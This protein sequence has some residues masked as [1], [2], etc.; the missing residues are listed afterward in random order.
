MPATI[1]ATT[2]QLSGGGPT[3]L[4][5]TH[6]VCQAARPGMRLAVSK[7]HPIATQ[8][9]SALPRSGRPG[10]EIPPIAHDVIL[11]DELKQR[12][13]S[14]VIAPTISPGA[15][16]CLV[17]TCGPT[18]CGKT[19]GA[20]YCAHRIDEERDGKLAY[21]EMAP[22]QFRNALWGRSEALVRELFSTARELATQEGYSILIVIED[23]EATLFRSRQLNTRNDYGCGTTAAGTTAELLHG[24]TTL[25]DDPDVAVTVWAS[26]NYGASTFSYDPAVMAEHRM[27]D[28]VE[29]PTLDLSLVPQVV[30]AHAERY[31]VSDSVAEWL[32]E[33]LTADIVLA[34]GRRVN[35]GVEVRLADCLTPAM[36]AGILSRACL[37]VPPQE[38]EIHD[39]ADACAAQLSV[40]ARRIAGHAETG[41]L[42]MI[43]PDLADLDR[44]EGLELEPVFEAEN[45]LLD[46]A[47]LTE[48]ITGVAGH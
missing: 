25:A 10:G 33:A 9:R 17:M 28:Y 48:V 45:A 24:L 22:G 5:T 3:R 38:M 7:I 26:S 40:L 2:G 37:N 29:F 12:L 4:Y 23:A 35:V 16:P 30:R 14:V 46:D 6:T 11:S 32:I 19:T 13:E 41:D 18:G 47:S 15:G 43:V 20:R 44:A 34:R 42:G 1:L 21:F 27:R 8:V 36:V 31:E 39:V